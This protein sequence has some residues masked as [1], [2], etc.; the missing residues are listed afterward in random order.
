MSEIKKVTLTKEQAAAI[1]RAKERKETHRIVLAAA[2]KPSGWHNGIY[3][4]LNELSL[5]KLMSALV[6]GYEIE[7]TPEEKVRKYYD[8][9]KEMYERYEYDID[10]GVLTGVRKTLDLLDIKIEGVNA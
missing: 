8:E 4:P 9:I 3:V 7:A 5:E 1:E 10:D 2:E 6:N